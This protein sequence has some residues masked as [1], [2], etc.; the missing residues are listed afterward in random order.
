M[1]K[2][3][4]Q[5]KVFLAD[6]AA[7]CISYWLAFQLRFDFNLPAE[8]LD[9]FLKTLPLVLSFR[10]AAFYY[11]GLYRGIWRFASMNDSVNIL[12]STV[13]S[14]LLLVAVILFIWHGTFARSVIILD[15]VFI[16]LLVGGIRFG[17][18]GTRELRYKGSSTKERIRV[19][20][21]GAGGIGEGVLRD[22]LQDNYRKYKVMGFL[23]DNPELWRHSIHGV[24]ILGGRKYLA[25]AIEKYNIQEV[26]VA[27]NSSRGPLI[28]ELMALCSG[29]RYHV[30]FRTV[31]TLSEQLSHKSSGFHV[32]QLRLADL[33]PRKKIDLDTSA[34]KGIISGKTVLV[35]GAGGTIGAELCRQI[36]NYDPGQILMLDNH[37]TALF[38]IEKELVE[39]GYGEQVTPIVGDVGDVIMLKNLFETHAPKVVF[40]AA[41]HKHVPLMETNPQEAV[42]N[43][44]LGTYALADA[45]VKYGAERFLYV[46]TDK[47]VRP[48]S[49]MGASKR[50]GEMVL[51]TF[52]RAGSTK[53]MSVR[54]GNVLGSSGSAVRIFQEQIQ[55]GGPITVTHPDVTRYFMTVEEAIQLILQ[56]C[57]M[58]SGGEIFVLNM[59]TPVK[60]V[61]LARNLIVLNGLEPDKEIKIKFTGMRPGEKM[62]E[63]LFRDE[64]VRKDTGHPDIF[65]AVPGES[66]VGILK[67]Q[68]RDLLKH[69]RQPDPVPVLT[70]IRALIPTYTGTPEAVRWVAE[71]TEQPR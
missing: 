50:L 42:R 13:V 9:R 38:Y 8:E 7:I 15:P 26:V 31:P 2:K 34:L 28:K 56:A 62:Y 63:E 65:M 32:R 60:V 10:L 33:L 16:M 18:R 22:F 53:F 27:V 61:D 58:G 49:V 12:K 71:K 39:A 52:S 30:K 36:L 23:D 67:E 51:H 20:I 59:G 14:Q 19:L 43:N 5:W 17:I 41:A 48:S 24:P 55:A 68:M 64:D 6:A 54:F 66:E 21:F 57:A 1:N 70:A 11:F 46:S 35:T 69:S 44:T 47:A 29:V 25:R 37:N 45:A 40:H 4:S 3:N